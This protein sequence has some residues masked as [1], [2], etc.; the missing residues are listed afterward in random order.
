MGIA[1]T[2]EML[3]IASFLNKALAIAENKA[4]YNEIYLPIIALVTVV[5]LNMLLEKIIGFVNV[6]LE[7]KLKKNYRVALVEKIAKLNYSYIE[8]EKSWN[9]IFRISKEPEIQI[10]DTYNSFLNMIAL[11]VRV[12]SLLS[13]LFYYSWWAA[14]LIL[15]VSVPLFILAI[16]GGKAIYEVSKEAAEERRKSDYIGLML[17]GREFVDERALFQY[18]N[19][20]SEKWLKIFE[21]VRMLE[22][23]VVKKWIISARIGGLVT[24]LLAV[25]ILFIFLKPLA[26]G[27]LTIGVF[28]SIG[29]GVMDLVNEMS[30]K[31][32]SLIQ[33]LS[34]KREYFKEIR[35]FF[36]LKEEEGSLDL[37][38]SG[39]TLETLEFKN[40]TF[41][42]PG[43][44][45]YIFKNLS[46]K[47]EKGK[48]Y[49]IVGANGSGKT[50][51]T[52]LITGLYK[53]FTGDI[54]INGKSIKD[55]TSGELKGLTSVVYQ[56]FARYFVSIKDNI[57]LGNINSMMDEYFDK[58]I[59]G[60]VE[61]IEIKDKID[62]LEKG[63]HTELGKLKEDSVDLSGGQWQRIAMARSIVSDADLRI[64]DE[65]TSA[66]D[67]VSESKVYENFERIS[68]NKTTIFISHRLGSTK[69][70]NEIF[71]LENG[72]LVEV[73]SHDH[74]MN[75]NGVYANMYESQRE[76]YA[77]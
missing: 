40:V 8:N 68:K 5:A 56:D 4:T 3:A 7:L 41:K 25:L 48:H 51:V 12:L 10:K 47:I 70:A 46:F 42:Y 38:S 34:K 31:L 13:V 22:F 18:G 32:S 59:D 65:P 39:L 37:P 21:K 75:L 71:V 60:A 19:T 20:L 62:S 73:G 28:I 63:I 26:D 76:W 66:L 16:K 54:L 2:L 29:Y 6:R 27:T 17:A 67:P 23:N 57:A 36:A 77:C 61:T 30:W 50:T 15:T 44:E 14:T 53:D 35:E 33:E 74:L 11:I 43:T 69:L 64:L 24:S 55:F 49:A 52:K 1:P 9:I 58:T 45:N 72:E